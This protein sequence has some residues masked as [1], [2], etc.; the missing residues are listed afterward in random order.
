MFTDKN[1]Q[2]LI[3]EPTLCWFKVELHYNKKYIKKV[4]LNSDPPSK[5]SGLGLVDGKNVDKREH[6]TESGQSSFP[7][8]IR[9]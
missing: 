9:H 5:V 8:Y 2:V 3:T 4:E 6:P 7:I 1:S